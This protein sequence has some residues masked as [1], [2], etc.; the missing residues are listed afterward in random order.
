M[1]PRLAV[2]NAAK[3]RPDLFNGLIDSEDCTDMYKLGRVP[4]G[5][6][7]AVAVELCQRLLRFNGENLYFGGVVAKAGQVYLIVGQGE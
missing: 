5:G 4:Q 2:L 6:D 7:E 3:R 1:E